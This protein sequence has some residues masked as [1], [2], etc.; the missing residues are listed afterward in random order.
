MYKLHIGLALTHYYIN[1][2]DYAVGKIES[3]RRDTD[4]V[5]RNK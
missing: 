5:D 4:Q 1:S 2:A 3:V